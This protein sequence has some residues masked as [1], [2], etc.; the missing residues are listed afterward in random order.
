[1][2]L[3]LWL[4]QC[5]DMDTVYKLRIA[6]REAV[7]AE[8]S[9]ETLRAALCRLLPMPCHERYVAVALLPQ[10]PLGTRLVRRPIHAHTMSVNNE[11]LVLPWF[12][13]VLMFV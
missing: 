1:M 8:A 3:A 4:T 10:K 7:R 6:A 13:R 5:K 11:R 2:R 9:P 12:A